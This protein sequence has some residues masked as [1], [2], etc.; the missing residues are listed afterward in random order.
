[1]KKKVILSVM[2][3]VMVIVTCVALVSCKEETV[4]VSLDYQ[5]TTQ[6]SA[7][8]SIKKGVLL[9]KPSDPTFVNSTFN[10]GIGGLDGGWADFEMPLKSP[11]MGEGFD[12]NKDYLFIGWYK[13]PECIRPWVFSEDRVYV[14]TTLY[15]KW[16]EI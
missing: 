13:E 9:T 2:L 11:R 5:I 16:I 15:A 6:F 10:D 8:W 7:V 14:K 4:N 3:L 1:M 12:V